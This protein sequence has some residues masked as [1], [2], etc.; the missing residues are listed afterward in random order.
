[1]LKTNAKQANDEQP[2]VL[3]TV[4]TK[5]NNKPASLRMDQDDTHSVDECI[6]QREREHK[7]A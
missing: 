1:M 5:T 4:S 2:A 6:N 7:L 3:G